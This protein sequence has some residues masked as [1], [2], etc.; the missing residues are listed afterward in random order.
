MKKEQETNDSGVYGEGGEEVYLWNRI[1]LQQ[2]I[3]YYI[4]MSFIFHSRC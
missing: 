2:Q 3:E 1:L 4:M